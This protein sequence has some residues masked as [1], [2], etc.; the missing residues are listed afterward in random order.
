V[1]RA[2]LSG[3]YVGDLL[4][5]MMRDINEPSQKIGRGTLVGNAGGVVSGETFR[6]WKR[7]VEENRTWITVTAHHYVL[8][9]TTGTVEN[10]ACPWRIQSLPQSKL[11]L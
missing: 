3:K 7:I 10:L 5:L 9:D 4:F 2:V 8:K 11:D 6:W 1:R